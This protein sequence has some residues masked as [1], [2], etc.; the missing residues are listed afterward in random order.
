[1]IISQDSAEPLVAF[2]RARRSADLWARLNQG[3]AQSLMVAFPMIMIQERGAVVQRFFRPEKSAVTPA[4]TVG[5]AEFRHFP[6]PACR[7]PN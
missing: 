5:Y 2:D 6:E 1:M 3:V 4:E 7:N